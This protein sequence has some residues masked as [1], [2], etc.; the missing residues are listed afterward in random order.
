MKW[1]T[2]TS[3]MLIIIGLLAGALAG[4]GDNSTPQ[5]GHS[6]LVSATSM[7][8]VPVLEYTVPHMQ[9]KIAVD[10][11]GYQSDAPKSAT[12]WGKR[13][14][15]EYVLVREEDGAQVYRGGI[16]DATYDEESGYYIGYADFEEFSTPGEYYLYGSGIGRSLTFSVRDDFYE[17]L[18]RDLYRELVGAC[19]DKS[20]SLGEI[21]ALLTTYEWYGSIYQTDEKEATPEFMAE[22]AG[23]FKDMDTTRMD[24]EETSLY[25]AVLAK[26]SY[27]YQK[28]DRNYATECLKRASAVYEQTQSTLHE[29]AESFYA[30]T[31]LYRATGLYTYRKQI[32][33]YKTFFQKSSSYFE[34][35]GYLYGSMTYMTTRQKVDVELCETFMENLLA[36]VEELDGC[37]EEMI[38][39]Y[40]ARNN[41]EEALLKRAVE[42]SFANYVLDS[43]QYRAVLEEFLHYLMGRNR[44]CT[45]FYPTKGDRGDYVFLLAQMVNANN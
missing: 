11:S 38:H 40:R 2:K 25:A 13:L 1:L 21:N 27:L 32:Q 35:S 44:D 17:T 23:W 8:D 33:E 37:Y 20:V 5:E 26:Y 7:E 29:D 24:S 9:P 31:E 43:L 4:C 16:E 12:L 30:V 18:F 45:S 41:G 28:Y 34:Q 10:C 42:M 39:P 22:L 36:R 19:H 3:A 14:P 15:D 6:T